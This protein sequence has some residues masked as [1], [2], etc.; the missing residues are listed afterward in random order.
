MPIDFRLHS[1]KLENFRGLKR[2]EMA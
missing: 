2:L 1:L